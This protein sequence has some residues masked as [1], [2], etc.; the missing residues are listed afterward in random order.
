MSNKDAIDKIVKASS[1]AT[2]E[3]RRIEYNGVSLLI[4]TYKLKP[5]IEVKWERTRDPEVERL[6]KEM[7]M[8]LRKGRCE[9]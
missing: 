5:L 2:V 6:A 9:S 1:G 4:T 7:G 3:Y 8:E